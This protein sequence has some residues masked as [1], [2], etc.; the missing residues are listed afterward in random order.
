MTEYS[1]SLN[2]RYLSLIQEIKPQQTLYQTA[3]KRLEAEL[4]DIISDSVLKEYI[5]RPVKFYVTAHCK[6]CEHYT[7]YPHTVDV[8]QINLW[9]WNALCEVIGRKQRHLVT[10]IILNLYF[11]DDSSMLLKNT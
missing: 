11:S 6:H 9:S 4:C 5:A 8:A 2:F 1:T 7:F 10:V 3:N